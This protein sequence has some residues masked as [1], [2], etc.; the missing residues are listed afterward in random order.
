[1]IGPS[2]FAAALTLLAL[3]VAACGPPRPAAIGIVLPL[4]GPTSQWGHE[5]ESGMRLALERSGAEIPVIIRDNA[6]SARGTSAA[7]ETLV[8]QGANVVVGPLTTDNAV[9]AGIV[10]RSLGIPCVVPAATG[11][12]VTR[13]GG[14][15][16]RIC[17]EDGQAGRALAQFARVDRGLTDLA[18]VIDLDSAYSLGLAEAFTLEFQRQRGRIVAELTY[19]GGSDD[20]AGVLDALAALDVQGALVA[21]YAPDLVVM[22]EQADDA[23]LAGLQLFGGDAWDGSGLAQRLP[24]RVAAAFHTRHFSPEDGQPAVVDF[25]AAWRA[26]H[27]EAPSDAAALGYDAMQLLLSCWQPDLDGAALLARLRAAQH[28]PGVTGA[29]RFDRYG[30]A[31]RKSIHIVQAHDPGA[32]KFVKRVDG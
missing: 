13:E 7:I 22:L 19:R 15:A 2:S 27:V 8:A 1:M 21:G 5:L 3:S 28:A 9:T 32:P 30:S 16:L 4:Q 25:L 31:S 23:R 20:R 29:V 10:A 11:P 26:R 6:G 18:V 14:W 17:Y 12:G 24:G